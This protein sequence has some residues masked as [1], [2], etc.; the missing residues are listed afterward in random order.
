MATALL[1]ADP[2][3]HAYVYF[4]T[5]HTGITFRPSP[6]EFFDTA[7]GARLPLFEVVFTMDDAT[8]PY[9]SWHFRQGWTPATLKAKA[10]AAKQQLEAYPE[11]RIGD[12]FT[13]HPDPAKAAYVFR[14]VGRTDDTFTLSSASNIHPGPVE[15]AIGAH[16]RIQGVVVIGDQRRQPAALVE[17][18]PTPPS[19]SSS[20]SS[21]ETLADD[22]FETVVRPANANMPAHATIRRTHLALLPAGSFVRTTT[23]LA[24]IVRNKTVAKN[25]DVIARLYREHGDQWQAKQGRFNSITATTEIKV[26]VSESTTIT[27]A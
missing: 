8:A 22:I 21:F 3:D 19:S 25:A 5:Q 4:D 11:Y 27:T 23:G 6:A 12:L 2:E 1:Q 13:P 20:D 9:A 7:T 24:K 18:L 10:A 26:E 16:P 17:L 15:R 14:F